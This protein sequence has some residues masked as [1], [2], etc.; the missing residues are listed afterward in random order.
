[1]IRGCIPKLLE[2]SKWGH[3]HGFRI[4]IQRVKRNDDSQNPHLGFR[5]QPDPFGRNPAHLSEGIEFKTVFK[6]IAGRH[7][8]WIVHAF[9]K[10]RLD[11][12]RY[13]F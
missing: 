12:I 1:M 4:R 10:K 2:G 3:S 9:F 5:S 6:K 13:D 7:E 11:I 8:I